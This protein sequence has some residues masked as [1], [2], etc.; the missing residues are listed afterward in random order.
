M[1]PPVLS[2]TYYDNDGQSLALGP[3]IGSAYAPSGERYRDEFSGED[4]IL[5]PVG[6]TR[7]GSGGS[8]VAV[9][10]VAGA[11][12]GNNGDPTGFTADPASGLDHSVAVSN[13]PTGFMA[14][15]AMS[16]RGMLDDPMIFMFAGAGGQSV[17]TFNSDPID[18]L[19]DDRAT[20]L[21]YNREK[22]QFSAASLATVTGIEQTWNQ[23]EAD[24]L[25]ARGEY[26]TGFDKMQD[27]RLA[28]YAAWFPGVAAPQL[29]MFQTGGYMRTQDNHWM[30]LDQV[31]IIRDRG[32][33]LIGPHHAVKIGDQTV[34]LTNEG[35][36][37]QGELE[38]WCRYEIRNGRA[39]NMLPP[40]TVARDGDTITI[41]ISTRSGETLR[42]LTGKYALYGGD[43]VNLGLE[44]IGGGSIV[45][46][47]VSGSDIVL[48]VTGTVTHIRNAHQR[49][50]AVNYGEPPY[51]D[52]NG[53]G[54]SAKRTLLAGTDTETVNVAGHTIELTRVVPTFEV[55]IT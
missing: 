52:V 35:Y 28:R 25:M 6:L 43:P 37:H 22:I 44:A 41:P 49:N 36:I 32:G 42:L 13:I 24:R 3:N 55:A 11:L 47:G 4:N 53:H 46:A 12:L 51:I 48:Q 10:T 17:N 23:G 39:W 5:M 29:F 38:A 45:S 33:V 30:M 1:T 27:E 54:Y 16:R 34:H 8:I 2:V 26:K 20:N 15:K 9:T 50:D 40:E 7:Y 31:D 14:A 18:G 19:T 21:Y